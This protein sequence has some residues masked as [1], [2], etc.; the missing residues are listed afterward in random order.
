MGLLCNVGGA[1]ELLGGRLGE[2]VADTLGMTF[3]EGDW[4]GEEPCRFG[5]MD[6]QNW[7][8]FR[9]RAAEELGPDEVP[10]LLTLGGAGRAVYLPSNVRPMTLS[11]SDGPLSCASLPGLRRELFDLADRWELPVDDHALEEILRGAEDPD[12]GPVVDA[13]EVMAFARLML[14]ANEA[15]RRDCPLWLMG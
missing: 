2:E 10:N 13:P 3:G 6:S 11:S 15:M 7:S 5:E 9:D 1:R 14:A 12:D 4:D 8:E